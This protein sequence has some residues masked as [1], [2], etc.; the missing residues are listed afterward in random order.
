MSNSINFYPPFHF[1]IPVG[2]PVSVG[3]FVSGRFMF[4][5]NSKYTTKKPENQA[6][7]NKLCGRKSGYF[8]Q[9]NDGQMIAWRYYNDKFQV[10]LYVHSGY[11]DGFNVG[12]GNAFV[13]NKIVEILPYMVYYFRLETIADT[14][15]LTINNLSM[16]NPETETMSCTTRKPFK[17]GKLINPWFGGNEVH[18]TS[19]QL[20]L[21]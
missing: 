8:T 3:N 17:T 13:T 11:G 16:I 18:R 20:Q 4:T 10:A 6:D 7:W 14:V 19:I 12:T 5:E 1:G 21:W 2:L 9:L 15:M